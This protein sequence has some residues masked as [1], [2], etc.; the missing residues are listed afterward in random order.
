MET[1]PPVSLSPPPEGYSVELIYDSSTQP[2]GALAQLPCT[3]FDTMMEAHIPPADAG[4]LINLFNRVSFPIMRDDCFVDVLKDVVTRTPLEQVE[5]RLKERLDTINSELDRQ[6]KSV[7]DSV[8]PQVLYTALSDS[9]RSDTIDLTGLRSLHDAKSFVVNTLPIMLEALKKEELTEANTDRG[10]SIS[11][12]H[13]AKRA[14][15]ISST[16]NAGG[17]SHEKPLTPPSSESLSSTPPL[18]GNLRRS[19]RIAAQ[20]TPTIPMKT[21]GVRKRRSGGR[22]KK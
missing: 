14:Q 3:H 22:K 9:Q 8:L 10:G 18:L 17:V 13:I 7:G 6:F 1:V 4:R 16:E 15:P 5:A 12:I 21:Q 11:N 20:Q 2:Q 19:R